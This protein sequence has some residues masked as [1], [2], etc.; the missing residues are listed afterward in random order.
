M[1]HQSCLN[2]F[3]LSSV[4]LVRLCNELA[5]FLAVIFFD[6]V[7]WSLQIQST[8]TTTVLA[9]VT[10]TVVLLYCINTCHHTL[11]H[12]LAIP[13]FTARLSLST[14]AYMG[15][16]K[17][18]FKKVWMRDHRGTLLSDLSSEW[19]SGQ[20]SREHRAAAH[21]KMNSLIVRSWVGSTGV[22]MQLIFL[23][24]DSPVAVLS[25]RGGYRPA[26]GRTPTLFSWTAVVLVLLRRA[27]AGWRAS[28]TRTY[29][30]LRAGSCADVHQGCRAQQG[31]LCL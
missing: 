22:L 19:D 27:A 26:V 23:A 10:S 7:F 14:F 4:G 25:L 28:L 24:A 2:W 21:K 15:P 9:A 5:A 20:D 3:A 6:I 29:S 13:F 30:K 8:A 31:L 1:A 18:G 17:D 16:N 12:G 11:S